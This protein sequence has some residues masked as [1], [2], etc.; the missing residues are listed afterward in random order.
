MAQFVL[1]DSLDVTRAGV[2]LAS[3]RRSSVLGA[4]GYDVTFLTLGYQQHHS[5]KIEALRSIGRLGSEVRVLNFFEF[6]RRRAK[7][8][9]RFDDQKEVLFDEP[10]FSSAESKREGYRAFRYFDSDG[11]YVKYKCFT[12]DGTLVFVDHRSMS[13]RRAR[14]VEYDVEGFR[15]RETVYSEPSGGIISR[16]YFDR[17]GASFLTELFNDDGEANGVHFHELQTVDSLGGGSK[18][19]KSIEEIQLEWVGGHLAGVGR[20]V[21]WLDQLALLGFF[22]LITVDCIKILVLHH[23]TEPSRKTPAAQKIYQDVYRDSD[24]FAAVVF[25]T[26]GQRRNAEKLYGARNNYF[27][28]PPVDNW[29]PVVPPNWS[30]PARNAAVSF[31]RFHPQHLQDAL[32]A[33]R[34]VVDVL[35]SAVYHIYG[36][37]TWR[38][39]LIRQRDVLGLQRNVEFLPVVSDMEDKLGEYAASILTSDHDALGLSAVDSLSAG[40]PVVSYR[41]KSGTETVVRNGQ[42]GFLVDYGD[43]EALAEAI[44]RIFQDRV[45]QRRMSASALE[46]HDRIGV[47]HYIQLWQSVL[48]KAGA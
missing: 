46:V 9:M 12:L 45:L 23:S 5:Q 16:K 6:Y 29:K 17:S 19:Y 27:V 47:E 41:T 10:G 15:V 21:V 3:E 34:Q 30:L 37:D 31:L 11:N 13:Q 2:E 32:M 22:K 33:F 40:V 26:D 24:Q 1:M 28:V 20:S 7:D 38:D 39:E 36:Y 35:P 4:A 42:D 18:V 48:D 44:L 25:A 43:T 14:K 8:K